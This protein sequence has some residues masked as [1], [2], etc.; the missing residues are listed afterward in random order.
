MI[1]TFKQHDEHKMYVLSAVSQ[2]DYLVRLR[3]VDAW[4]SNNHIVMKHIIDVVE[5][6]SYA[7][8]KSKLAKMKEHSIDLLFDNDPIIVGTVKRGGRDGV[9]V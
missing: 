4:L 6:G 1:K 7:Q 5:G 3:E 8:G 9:L 2:K